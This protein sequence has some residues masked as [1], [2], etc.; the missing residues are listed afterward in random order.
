MYIYTKYVIIFTAFFAI[1]KN[2]WVA[3]STAKAFPTYANLQ[4]IAKNSGYG[5]YV[6]E[7]IQQAD[8]DKIANLIASNTERQNNGYYILPILAGLVTFLA[9]YISELHTKLKNKKANTVAKAASAEMGST[10]KVMKIVLPIIMVV[11]T[12]SASAS[13]GMYILASNVATIALGELS[14]LIINVLTKK[15]KSKTKQLKWH[16]NLKMLNF[17]LRRKQARLAKS[18]VLSTLFRFPKLLQRLVTKLTA[19]RLL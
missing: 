10:M 1:L 3:D 11:F 7:N 16:R 4:S 8:Y 5:D 15:K 6:A 12:L 2:I 13:F 19:T 18:S 17:Q 14:S 9:Q